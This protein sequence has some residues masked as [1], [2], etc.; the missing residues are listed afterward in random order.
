MLPFFMK[1]LLREGKAPQLKSG[2]ARKSHSHVPLSKY[3]LVFPTF[4]Q[5]TPQVVVTTA[6]ETILFHEGLYSSVH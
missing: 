2:W 3:S 1:H 5:V 6:T 4:L